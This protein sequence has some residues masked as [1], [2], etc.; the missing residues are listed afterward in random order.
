MRSITSDWE[1]ANFVQG[2]TVVRAE[3]KQSWVNKSR[4]SQAE[5][6][7]ILVIV[8]TVVDRSAKQVA[9]RRNLCRTTMAC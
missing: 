1:R 7:S 2:Q 6:E 4:S 5:L 9:Y 8:Q 3:P